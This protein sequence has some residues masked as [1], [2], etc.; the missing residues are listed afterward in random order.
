MSSRSALVPEGHWGRYPVSA[1]SEANLRRHGPGHPGPW[2]MTPRPACLVFLP[3]VV[4][5]S[6][7]PRGGLLQATGR[8]A[9]HRAEPCPRL[10]LASSHSCPFLHNYKPPLL[11]LRNQEIRNLCLWSGIEFGSSAQGNPRSGGAWGPPTGLSLLVCPGRLGLDPWSPTAAK[12]SSGKAR[13]R[14]PLAHVL[15]SEGRFRMNLHCGMGRE[16]GMSVGGVG[17]GQGLQLELPNLAEAQGPPPSCLP[18]LPGSR[19][20]KVIS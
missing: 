18:L 17:E 1:G 14:Q 9:S 10:L 7:G 20:L 3:W 6:V 4:E 11:L 8:A 13:G 5:V 2:S 16:R 19:G 15:F 12:A